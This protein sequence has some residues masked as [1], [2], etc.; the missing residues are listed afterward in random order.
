MP[1]HHIGHASQNMA[2]SHQQLTKDMTNQTT[3]TGR[4]SAYYAVPNWRGGWLVTEQR[5]IAAVDYEH[6]YDKAQH[7]APLGEALIDLVSIPNH[8][9]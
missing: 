1:S 3:T 6:A 8:G 5:I 9:A 4:W 2:E 7:D